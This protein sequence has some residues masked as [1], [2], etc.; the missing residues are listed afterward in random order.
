MKTVMIIPAKGYS[1]RLPGKNLRDFCGHPL[2]AWSITQGVNAKHVDE[3]WVSTD[4]EE[5]KTVAEYYGAKVMMRHYKDELNTPG[6][7]PIFEFIER[8]KESGDLD[9]EDWLITRLCTTPTLLPHDTDVCWERLQIM[10]ELYGIESIG[11]GAELRTFHAHRKLAEGLSRNLPQDCLCENIGDIVQ[12]GAWFGVNKVRNIK[13]VPPPALGV[14]A[15]R[16]GE[17]PLCPYYN[18]QPWQIQVVDTQAE[19]DF[20]EVVA[21]H[22]ILKGRDM[23]D[24]Y[25]AP[26]MEEETYGRYR[27]GRIG[28]KHK[29]KGII[30]Q[31]D[32]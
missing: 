5:V 27:N 25:Q 21:E 12:T 20:A 14:Q 19:F 2:V 1:S 13:E 18:V 6:S 32:S 28:Q 7:I 10:N 30:Q 24:V 17:Y 8:Q 16:G 26:R 29:T 3:V 22:Y 9:D 4:S 23:L 15:I 11:V 31:T